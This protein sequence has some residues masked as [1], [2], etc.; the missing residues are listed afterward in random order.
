LSYTGSCILCPEVVV[1]HPELVSW[2]TGKALARFPVSSPA[3]IEAPLAAA[4]AARRDAAA[5]GALAR[6]IESG[7]VFING[8][9]ASD[10]RL[11]F[12]GVKRSGYG[13]ELGSFGIREFTNIQTAW[14]GPE[15]ARLA[16]PAQ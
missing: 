12:G 7:M 4:H 8:M 16:P 11:P 13:R 3:E 9:V 15:R 10:P 5:A 2:A 14:I 1:A 6:S